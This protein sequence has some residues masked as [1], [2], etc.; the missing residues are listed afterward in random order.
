MARLEA[1][2]DIPLDRPVLGWDRKQ[3]A[4]IWWQDFGYMPGGMWCFHGHEHA[5][6]CFNPVG[7]ME[8]P[9]IDPP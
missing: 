2:E 8:L 5:N 9:S 1:I 7:W 4:V 3:W 6:E